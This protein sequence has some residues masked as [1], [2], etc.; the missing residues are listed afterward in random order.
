MKPLPHPVVAVLAMRR[1]TKREL[2]LAYGC[3]EHYVSRVLLGHAQPSARFR[4]FV[5]DHLG[6]SPAE[7]WADESE[8]SMEAAAS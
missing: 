6:V 5:P 8:R 4:K 7:V 2:A 3:S 1:V